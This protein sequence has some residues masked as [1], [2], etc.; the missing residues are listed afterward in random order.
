MKKEISRIE[1]WSVVRI[2]FF[3]GLLSGF[4][5]GIFSGYFT[6]MLADALGVGALPPDAKEMAGLSGGAII[7][8]AILMGLISSLAWALCGALGAM[9]YNMIAR[10]FGGLEFV[11]TKEEAPAASRATTEDEEPGHE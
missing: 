7:A 11:I 2:G 3:F 1:P 9:F 10:L 6:K 5:F 4:L 8:L